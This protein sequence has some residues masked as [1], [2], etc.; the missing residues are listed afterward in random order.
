MSEIFNLTI[1]FMKIG[2]FSLGG[3]NSMIQLIEHESVTVHHWVSQAEFNTITGST[4]LFPGLTAV[5]ISALIGYKVAGY[6]GMLSAILA[7]NL[8][9]IILAFF[10]INFIREHQENAIIQKLIVIVQYGG[11]VL[12]ASAAYAMFVPLV[13]ENF[14]WKLLIYSIGLFGAVALMDFSPFIALI[15]FILVCLYL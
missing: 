2:I 11:M 5:K 3:G 14:S 4:F 1:S 6:L 13:S 9:G 10:F 12:L 15:I 7:I 8:P